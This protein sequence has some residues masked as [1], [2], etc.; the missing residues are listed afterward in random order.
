MPNPSAESATHPTFN[1]KTFHRKFEET[2]GWLKPEQF[3]P[4]DWADK[5][6]LEMLFPSYK[7]ELLA[8]DRSQ[9]K[10]KGRAIE[11]EDFHLKTPDNSRY[12]FEKTTLKIESHKRCAVYGTNGS[13]KT[14]LFEAIVAGEI[15][16]F[17]KHVHVHHMKEL[18][19]NPQAEDVSVLDTVLCSHPLR[20]VLVCMQAHLKTLIEDEKDAD[21]KSALN[22]NLDYVTLELKYLKAD[23]AE[24]EAKKS[25]RVLGFDE[26][27]FVAP[28]SS[29]SGGLRMRVALASA[30]FI[31]PELLLLDEPTNHLDMPSVLWL[32]N[33]LRG[34]KGSYLLVTHDRTLLENVVT[35]V[36]LLQDLKIEYFATDFKGFEKDK[37]KQDQS[38]ERK[39]EKFL[40]ANRNLDTSSPQYRLKVQYKEWQQRR[41][42]RFVQLA[43][44]FTFKSPP[45]LPNPDCLPEKEVSLIKID[46]VRFSYD[47][48]A[49]LPFIF[50]NPVSYEVKQG[51]RVGVMGPNG[52]GKSTF[53][54]LITKKLKATE[55]KVTHNKHY[56]LAYFGQH[57]T[58]ELNMENTPMEFMRKQFPK[59]KDGLLNNHL[60]KSSITGDSANTIMK[61]LSYS[62][63][64]CVIFAKLTY[65]PPHL[66]IMDEPTNFLDL[67]S[68]DSLIKA[69]NNFKG[70]LITVTHNRDFLKR[71]SKTFLSI[72]PGAFLEFP[73]MKAAE[74]ATYSFITAM[75]EGRQVDAKT[76]ILENRG[77]GAVHTE[78]DQ[79]KRAKALTGQQLAQ[80][81]KED[82][83]VAE[84]KLKKDIADKKAAKAAAKKAA[85][86]LDWVAGDVCWAPKGK[87]FVQAEVIRNV[88]G[89]GVTLKMPDGSMKM[90]DAKKL[91]QEK[92]EEAAPKP[93]G[94]SNNKGGNANAK[95]GRGGAQGARGGRGG[96]RGGARGRGGRR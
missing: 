47:A 32:E 15:R 96:A 48:D 64:S 93:K 1:E 69:A 87:G 20:R 74:R 51:T 83:E 30:F 55:G 28:M 76:A 36:M 68:V 14:T 34:Y 19:H 85:Q 7:R 43:G 63:R 56:K 54:K 5:K 94:A 4:V 58:K 29:L 49:G 46:N 13:G 11:I 90:I 3:P 18:E 79:A 37:E 80:K 71:T 21:R 59:E 82:A 44:K 75:E 17:P 8:L 84:L 41:L 66:L 12:L 27:G 22:D 33:R 23:I 35:S 70:G 52:A 38:R 53:L 77:G 16:D 31:D 62:Q 89:M 60:S 25:L 61:N 40:N 2:F 91:K 57:S 72:V 9:L 67:E 92:P 86:K 6:Q 24:E 95:G 39:I 78:E 26:V 81:A 50:D 88:R 10:N 73:S 65:E 45:A 42:D